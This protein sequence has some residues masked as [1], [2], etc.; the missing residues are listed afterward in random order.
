MTARPGAVDGAAGEAQKIHNV[1]CDEDVARE[2]VRRRNVFHMPPSSRIL[3]AAPL[4]WTHDA[5]VQ[6]SSMSPVLLVA[7]SFATAVQAAGT[8]TTEAGDP[9]S[10]DTVLVAM[11]AGTNLD[12]LAARHALRVSRRPGPSG[13]A[14]L[15]V[16]PTTYPL[17]RPTR[18]A[19][20]ERL[21][22]DATVRAASL[23]GRTAG[24]SGSALPLADT[25]EAMAKIPAA[26]LR[27][28]QWHLPA[29]NVPA[30]TP[31]LAGV[32]IA[33]LDTGVAYEDRVEGQQTWRRARTLGCTRFLHPADFIQMDG[34]PNDDHQH[35]THITSLIAGCDPLPGLARGVSILPV[36]V[37]DEDDVGTELALV[38][39]IH[40]A[41]EHGAHIINMSLSFGT[42]YIPGPALVE[43]LERADRAG[44]VLVAAAGNEA[45]EQVTQPAASPLV[46]AVGA[47]RP[48][49]G[50][51]LA[52]ARFSN[53]S[54]RVDLSAPGGSLDADRNGDGVVDGLLGETIELQAPGRPTG[55]WLYAGTSQAAAPV[56]AAAAWLVARGL[57][58]PHIR[59]VLTGTTF[60]E[61]L[62][63]QPWIDGHGSGRLDLTRALAG[64][65]HVQVASPAYVALLPW[66]EP[67][68]RGLVRPRLH[69]VALDG[70][71]ARRAGVGVLGM[72][73]GS[74]TTGWSCRTQSHGACVVAGPWVAPRDNGTWTWRVDKVI[75]DGIATPP[76]SAAFASAGV[77]ALLGEMA[78]NPPTREAVLAFRWPA[79]RIADLGATSESVAV[80]DLDVQRA[81]T[82]RA[83]TFIA[84]ALRGTAVSAAGSMA[85][86]AAHPGLP[87][88]VRLLPDDPAG[89]WGWRIHQ[90]REGARPLL[91]LDAIALGASA[92]EV[93]ATGFLAG[94]GRAQTPI[95]IGTG[96]VPGPLVANR[97][98]GTELARTPLGRWL[99]A[100]GW[101]AWQLP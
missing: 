98:N 75:R 8:S 6:V 15:Q 4:A 30:T 88:T 94:I 5:R 100:G 36:K 64:A 9:W 69:V 93:T 21:L 17:R 87:P 19:V 60:Q 28:L 78:R 53:A 57:D 42:G 77:Q 27:A 7:L 84:S 81:Q 67:G 46:L 26:R 97:K 44:V 85:I 51:R 47:L 50:R 66:L 82:P 92:L 1:V 24:A 90:T 16:P 59:T 37:L 25:P 61:V 31:A 3:T 41:V 32:I 68:A 76:A 38:D 11:H 83:R 73:E 58:A 99:E 55:W 10:P 48:A 40:H 20:L 79:T 74:R 45:S 70:R 101:P 22:H 43:A 62:A 33:V 71:G 18:E 34:H 91:V 56:S 12:A 29:A 65:A 52:P 35:G 86:S 96:A 80:V 63:G 2:E 95:L 23:D 14:A 89:A 49:D 72:L 54:T 39:G 13:W